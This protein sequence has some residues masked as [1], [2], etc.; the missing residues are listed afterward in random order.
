[1]ID[2][3]AIDLEVGIGGIDAKMR[4]GIGDHLKVK[5]EIGRDPESLIEI[6]AG[7]VEMMLKKARSRWYRCKHFI[8]A[9]AVNQR[10]VLTGRPVLRSVL[11]PITTG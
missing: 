8:G 6:G 4:G 3:I 11:I 10:R 5:I 7:I 2:V 1:M 9:F